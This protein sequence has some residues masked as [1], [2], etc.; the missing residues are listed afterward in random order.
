MIL[1]A[2]T[3]IVAER[4]ENA[5]RVTEVANACEVSV[6]TL[7]LYFGD[8]E[9][10]VCAA[11]AE[12]FRVH[13]GEDFPAI[14]RAVESASDPEDYLARLMQL[15]R[16]VF[17]ADRAAQRFER[18]AIVGMAAWR[19]DLRTALGA[20]YRSYNEQIGEL[21]ERARR[22]GLVREDLE[23]QAT[24]QF[25]QM[26]YFGMSVRDVTD[27][28]DAEVEASLRVIERALRSFLPTTTVEP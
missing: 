10:L 18:A 4:G 27:P 28:T 8:R 7:Y 19:P 21:F 14:E 13:F 24:A 20:F 11:L 5:L 9:G 16:V 23:P 2:A 15:A 25:T 22:R 12:R 26:M 6:A 3:Q 17:G 1:A